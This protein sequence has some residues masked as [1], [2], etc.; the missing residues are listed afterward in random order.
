MWHNHNNLWWRFFPR[1]ELTRI[2]L[3]SALRSF[4]LSLISL[5]VPLYLYKELG[6]TLAQTL[7]FFIFYSVIFAIA[8]PLAAKYCARFGVKH[9]VL[10]SVP[11]YL[12]FILALYLM[13][14]FST[15]LFIIAT[16]LGMSLGFYWMGMHHIFHKASNPKHR[17]EEVGKRIGISI[18]AT[19]IGPLIGGFLIKYFGFAV[20]FTLCGGVLVLSTIVLFMSKEKHVKYHFSIK[21]VLD[22]HHWKN[23]L[24]F[25]SK[26]SRII[27]DG[28]VWPLF[29]FFILD[30]Y[31]SLG[32]IG[33]IIGG[34]TGM[35]A[36]LSGKYSDH[37]DKRKVA[38]IA[39][40]F[41]SVGWIFRALVVTP[42]HVFTTTIFS[43]F[44][45]GIRDSPLSAIEYDKAKGDVTGYFVYKEIYLCLGRVLMLSFLLIA[46]SFSGGLIMQAVIN[47]A[48]FLF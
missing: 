24:F 45:Q 27:A 30:D 39:T 12:L 48:T 26:G 28:V 37:I 32:I 40:V 41:D 16:F 1:K 5:F 20:V 13:P 4:G 47:F 15:P 46:D 19:V 11:F 2:Y 43:T 38:Q 21:S 33:S 10:L 23:S 18:L 36:W 14:I 34:L 8:T 6:F 44:T 42:F 25:I 35:V 22:L 3:S 9:S 29:I 31:F 17:G 7:G